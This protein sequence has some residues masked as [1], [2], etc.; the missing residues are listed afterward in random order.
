MTCS[1]S[2]GATHHNACDRREEYLRSL[3]EKLKAANDC[4]SVLRNSDSVMEQEATYKIYL[5]KVKL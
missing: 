1:K 2:E 4:I 3:E 5:S